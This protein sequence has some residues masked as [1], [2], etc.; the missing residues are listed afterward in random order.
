LSF[1]GPSEAGFLPDL[2]ENLFKDQLMSLHAPWLSLRCLQVEPLGFGGKIL[3]G[4]FGGKFLEG[5][6][7]ASLVSWSWFG[8]G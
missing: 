1:A 5:K 8:L 7:D 3:E 4:N 2:A 6:T